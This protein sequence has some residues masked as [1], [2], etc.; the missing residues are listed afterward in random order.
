MINSILNE[1][2]GKN[3]AILGFG[4]EGKATYHF[5]RRYSDMKLTIIDKRNIL[6]DN[7]YLNDDKNISVIYGDDY[8]NDL[9]KYDLVIK[10]PGVVTK[11]IDVSNINFS[12][13]LE[14]LLKYNGKNTIGVTATKGKST[15]STLA[16]EVIKACNPNVKLLGNIGTAIFDEIESIREDTLCVVEMSAL[17][18]EYVVDSPHIG[19]IINLY[20]DHLDHAGS[21]EHYHQ[22]KLNMFKYQGKEDYAIYSKDIEPLNSYIDSKYKAHKYGI[23]LKN[24][25]SENT[26]HID[27][28]YVVLNNEKLYNINDERILIGE[29][30]LRNIMIVLTIAKILNLDMEKVINTINHFK[31]LEHR[32]QYVG[33][34]D[35]VLY[36]DDA[37]ST[38]PISCINAIMSLQKVDTLILGG[39]DRGISYQ[40]LIDYLNTGVVRNLIC[41]PETGY[42][43]ADS[44]T[45]EKVNVYKIEL[46]EDACKKA[47]EITYKNMICVL[48]PAASSYNYFK[49]YIEKGNAF[50][51]YI[52]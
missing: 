48:S 52:K 45:N 6:E 9:E 36:Y 20:E 24:D 34:Y 47:K 5:I 25:N 22:D 33:T 46:L 38:V 41:M 37:I 32:L 28:D 14:L 15:T 23:C 12:S 3:V 40:D 7:S 44:I 30:N 35:G 26:T 13:E 4:T 27:G 18:L 16:Y 19:V 8:L 42:K 11:D 1:L 21:V 51:K 17:Q 39:L 50:Q 10:G 49:N 31:G 29:H 2:K 43:I